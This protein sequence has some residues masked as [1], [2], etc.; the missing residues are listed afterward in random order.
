MRLAAMAAAFF[1]GGCQ[2]ARPATPI[3]PDPSV[4]LAGRWT[5]VAVNGRPTG[6]GDRF[7][8][9]FRPDY[10]VAQFGCNEGSGSYRIEN[11]WLVTGDWII[12]AA[13][14]PGRQQFERPGFKVLGQPLAIERRG[15]GVRLRGRRGSIDLVR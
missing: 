10:G 5:I 12:T 6:G 14:C 3:A 11:G 9:D 15:N 8:I 2:L 7:D 1:L 4:S 13:G